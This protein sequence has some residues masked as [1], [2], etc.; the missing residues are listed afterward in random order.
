M[1]SPPVRYVTTPDG[2]RIAYT[3]CGEGLPFVF[4]PAWTNHVQ[5]VWNGS[6]GNLL[7]ALAARF[8]LITYDSR[9]MGLSTRALGKYLT[10]DS[11]LVDLD[12]VLEKQKVDRF[13][14]LGSHSSALLAGHY[15]ARHPDRV[16]ALVLMNSGVCWLGDAI[17]S[18]W[19]ELPRESW[20]TFLYSLVPNSLG[21]QAGQVLSML[22]LG[23]RRGVGAPSTEWSPRP[24]GKR[25][26]LRRA[27]AGH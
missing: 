18:L 22:P 25:P 10:L 13:I 14:L 12:A 8:H 17:P 5:A 16:L 23:R 6:H 26:G 9:G 27:R 11:Y 20:D 15:A 7:R 3:A 4:M 1:E 2:Y 19:D 21:D 24:H